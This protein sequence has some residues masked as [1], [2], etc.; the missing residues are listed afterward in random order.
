[1][2]RNMSSPLQPVT[3]ESELESVEVEPFKEFDFNLQ[4]QRLR[5]AGYTPAEVSDL[6]HLYREHIRLLGELS[7]ALPDHMHADPP[8]WQG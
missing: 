7:A 2:P 1:M 5:C 4:T 6:L 3:A 8:V